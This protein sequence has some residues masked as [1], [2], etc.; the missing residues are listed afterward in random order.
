MREVPSDKLAPSGSIK[1]PI[2]SFSLHKLSAIRSDCALKVTALLCASSGFGALDVLQAANSHPDE[3]KKRVL[4][5]I[6]LLI[7]YIEI[8]ICI[9]LGMST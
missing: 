8:I 2:A 7:M 6:F 3:I 1:I 5:S 9:L 4:E